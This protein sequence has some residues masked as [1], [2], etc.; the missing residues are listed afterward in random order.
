MDRRTPRSGGRRGRSARIPLIPLETFH[1]VARHRSFTEAAH[2]LGISQPAVT[3]Q[4]RRLER[5]L[6]LS[7]FDRAGR[8]IVVTDA[9]GTLDEFAQRIF[10]LLDAAREA[11]ENLAGLHTGHLEIG[12]SRTAG[13]YYVARLLDGFK[14]RYPGVKVSLRVSNS[15]TILARVLD[16]SLHAGLVAGPG[17]NPHLVSLPVV[18]DRL[19]VILPPGHRLTT[20][21][22]VTLHDLEGCPLI[23]REPGSATRSLIERAFHTRG[24]V[25]VPSMELESNEAI[26]YAVADGIGVGLMAHA[27]VAEELATKRLVGRPLRD[28]LHLDFS[29]VYHRDR[30]LSRV[31]TAF[32]ALLPEVARQTG[33]G[34]IPGAAAGAL[35]RVRSRGH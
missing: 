32:L 23:L 34:K 11:L 27:A 9:G 16:F 15:E 6:G 1:L 24:L 19:L 21:A 18:R 2:R 31:V 33:R 28:P 3:Q 26:K 8:R 30:T 7:L 4:I 13:A 17:E 25:A 5:S 35:G 14:R 10:H 22:A 29:L 12:A 20:K